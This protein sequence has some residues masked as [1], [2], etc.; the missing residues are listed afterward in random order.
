MC[1]G[2][3]TSEVEKRWRPAGCSWGYAG[4]TG[5]EAGRGDTASQGSSGDM[6]SRPRGVLA[7]GREACRC[8]SGLSAIVCDDA[9]V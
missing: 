9:C 5:L 4:E 8:A 2:G 6:V 3:L 7:V 1:P